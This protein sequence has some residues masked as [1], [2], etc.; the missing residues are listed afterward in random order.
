[1][2]TRTQVFLR[3]RKTGEYV[4]AALIDGV[5]KEEVHKA[6][7]EWR[8]YMKDAVRQME[9]EGRPPKSRPQHAHWDWNKKHKAIA[10]LLAYQMFGVECCAKMQGLMLLTT[11]GKFSRL[12]VQKGNGLVY[13][14]FV[15]TAPWNSP[16]IVEPIY[17]QVGT[18]LIAAAIDVSI[19][20][21]FKG[22]IGLHA[23]PQ[24]EDWYANHC[25]MTDLGKDSGHQDLRYFEMTTEQSKKFLT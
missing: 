8:P 18:V 10:D 21:G 11:S 17:S 12:E 9:K 1:M 14:A 2:S 20:L 3:R 23:L 13:V 6:E 4:D 19:E 15:E 25:E 5:T 7:Q 22:R 16:I 24:A